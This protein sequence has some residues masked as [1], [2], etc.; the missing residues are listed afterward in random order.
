MGVCMKF[1][2]FI[3]PDGEKKR[4]LASIRLVIIAKNEQCGNY[5]L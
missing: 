5:E 2:N 4:S 3:D 1:V